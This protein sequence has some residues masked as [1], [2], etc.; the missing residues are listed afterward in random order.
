MVNG[1][2][3][4]LNNS[5][6]LKLLLVVL[7]LFVNGAVQVSA[8]EPHPYKA[9]TADECIQE[10]ECVWEHFKLATKLSGQFKADVSHRFSRWERPIKISYTG[11][12][13]DEE[14]KVMGGLFSQIQ[15]YFPLGVSVGQPYTVLFTKTESIEKELKSAPF[16]KLS[17]QIAGDPLSF[18]NSYKDS[19]ELSKTCDYKKIFKSGFETDIYLF[20]SIIQ[21]DEEDFSGCF[22]RTLY[23][24]TGLNNLNMLSPI[25]ND[26][27][28]FANLELLILGLYYQPIFKSGM[29]LDQIKETFDL[30]YEEYTRIFLVNMENIND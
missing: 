18:Y 15:P 2:L 10:K 19:E 21:D 9:T 28:E 30:V 11:P 1:F 20:F 22:K 17:S 25:V 7:V 8:E 6:A 29:D 24:V 13:S 23:G 3:S 26:G 16:L 5:A 4:I 12:F 14:K 27:S